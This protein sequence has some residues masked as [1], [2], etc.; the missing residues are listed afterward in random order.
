MKVPENP[1]KIVDQMRA[2]FHPKDRPVFM[3][4]TA[5]IEG[6]NLSAVPSTYPNADRSRIFF[7][8]DHWWSQDES[9]L[10]RPLDHKAPD[11]SNYITLP[12][13]RCFWPLGAHLRTAGGS[14]MTDVL[15]G[16]N[17]TVNAAA[18]INYSNLI[19]YVSFNGTT[20]FLSYVDDPHFDASGTEAN[21]AQKG[22]TIG[23]WFFYDLAVGATSQGL[24][25]KDN[26]T[27]ARSYSLFRVATTGTTRFGVS[28][29]GTTYVSVTS[30]A[31]PTTGVWNFIVG[32]YKPST[33][34]DV[35]QNLTVTTLTAS[36][37]ASIFDS[38]T[39]FNIGAFNSATL[40]LDGNCSF[41][42]YCADYLSDAQ[43]QN[44]YLTDKAAYGIVG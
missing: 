22:L 26:T 43:L 21:I 4:E 37:P 36:I 38:A 32:R 23:G 8:N 42:F 13:I 44:L 9:G 3:D 17:L 5:F 31:A 14:F 6:S 12:G 25:T 34:L 2:W 40:F 29:N 18:Q 24:I 30:S 41:A 16:F 1:S 10:I 20:Q 33:S 39:A 11:I 19:P 7:E 28:A 35:W 27:N 15:N